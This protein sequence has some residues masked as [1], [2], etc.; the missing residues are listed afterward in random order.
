MQSADD[1]SC[2]ALERVHTYAQTVRAVENARAA[3]F[4]NLSLDLIYGLPEQ[5][6]TRW[7]ENLDAALSLAPE[8]LSCYGLKVEEA[9]R[10]LRSASAS[11]CR[12]TT[13]RRICT[14]R[15]RFLGAAW[16]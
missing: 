2:G 6:M 5:T 13:R 14:S 10:S 16:L 11:R 3:G 4:D 12:T 9:R 15:G 7:Q 1:R 8:H